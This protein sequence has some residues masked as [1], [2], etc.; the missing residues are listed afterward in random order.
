MPC[1]NLL[2]FLGTALVVGPIG[3]GLTALFW[4]GVTTANAANNVPMMLVC[5]AICGAIAL[6]C[7]VVLAHLFIRAVRYPGGSRTCPFCL[8]DVPAPA[9]VCR[10]CQRDLPACVRPAPAPPAPSTD[11][12]RFGS[13]SRADA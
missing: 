6:T 1:V 2:K 9:S 8:S 13:D 11:W 10:Y 7:L 3:G 12:L 5:G 4:I